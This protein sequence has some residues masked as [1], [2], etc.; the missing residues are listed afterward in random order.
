[1][2]ARHDKIGIKHVIRLEW[3]DKTLDM[4]LAGMS[5]KEIRKELDVFLSDKKQ[6]GG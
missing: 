5:P 2:S 4:M 3:M 6:S 1:M